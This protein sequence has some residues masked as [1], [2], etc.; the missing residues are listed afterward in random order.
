MDIYFSNS[1]FT[2]FIT[3]T[4][5]RKQ[6]SEYYRALY[7]LPYQCST[8]VP[9]HDGQNCQREGRKILLP[10]LSVELR[11]ALFVIFNLLAY[12]KNILKVRNYW[13]LKNFRS[14]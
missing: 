10:E 13:F 12:L 7:D 11:S 5:L 1:N 4:L 8:L 3:A 2:V 14:R 6:N 9:R